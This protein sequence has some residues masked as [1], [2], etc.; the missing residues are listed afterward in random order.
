MCIRDS[1]LFTTVIVGHKVTEIQEFCDGISNHN[2]NGKF[3]LAGN[4]NLLK[5]VGTKATIF[6]SCSEFEM[7]INTQIK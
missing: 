6:N 4:I 5:L 7:Y 2:S 3:L 1:Y